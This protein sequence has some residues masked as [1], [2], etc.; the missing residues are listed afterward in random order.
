[1]NKLKLS[2]VVICCNE[3]KYIE[4]CLFSLASQNYPSSLFEVL[5]IENGSTDKTQELV[6]S[7]IKNYSNMHLIISDVCGTAVNRNRGL[8]EANSNFVAFIDGD[9]TAEKDWLLSLEKG[10]REENNKN[11]RIAAIGG[12]NIIPKNAN[13]FRKAL[14]IAVSNYW[15]NSGSLQAAIFKSK[16]VL[17]EHIPTLNVLY[18]KNKIL[19][20]GGFDE[21]TGN[22]GED[23]DLSH[24]LRWEGY[25]LIYDSKAVVRHQWRNTFPSWAKNMKLYGKSTMLLVF[26]NRRFMKVKYLAPFV[27]LLSALLSLF[28]S[29]NHLLA[30]PFIIYLLVTILISFYACF[31]KK[32]PKY[33]LFVFLIYLT[34]HISYGVG[35]IHALIVTLSSKIRTS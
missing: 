15:G 22:C 33:L 10:F 32:K 21:S 20:I 5:I 23:F 31:I 19:E 28:N 6:K 18:D 27:V 8:F 13:F 29:I 11:D 2:V 1:M 9:C 12:P 4:E 34:T 24:R 14:S 3:E 30:L 26:K 7:F 17:V 35:Q 25:L 16:R